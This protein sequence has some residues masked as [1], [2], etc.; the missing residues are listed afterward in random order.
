M[1]EVF[2]CLQLTESFCMLW[3]S[4]AHCISRMTGILA[5]QAVLSII[6]TSVHAVALATY[7]TIGPMHAAD[8]ARK[9]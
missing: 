4:I 1:T 2:S 7:Q 6:A 3:E 8:S 9:Q 5:V